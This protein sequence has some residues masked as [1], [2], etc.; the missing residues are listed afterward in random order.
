MKLS[1]LIPVLILSACGSNPPDATPYFIDTDLKECREY[2]VVNKTDYSIKFKQSW[3]LEH[4]NGYFAVP[5]KQAA[6]WKQYLLDMAS[7]N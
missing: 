7:G 1:Y 6:E 3:P 5:G 4:C 2:E